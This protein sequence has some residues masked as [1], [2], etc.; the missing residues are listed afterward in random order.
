MCM[1]INHQ[2]SEVSYKVI[3]LATTAY[4]GVWG[5]WYSCIAN[6]YHVLINIKQRTAE[7]SWKKSFSPSAGESMDQGRS[8]EADTAQMVQK[9]YPTFYTEVS[10]PCSQEPII[11]VNAAHTF[12]SCL[13][14]RLIFILSIH[15]RPF[16]STRIHIQSSFS[17]KKKQPTGTWS[18]K[19]LICGY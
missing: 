12:I 15:L 4:T 6:F 5:T 9:N 14:S 16:Y 7:D 17:F 11:Q 3:L 13:P 2:P 10:I 19:L 18:S 8:W 1:Y